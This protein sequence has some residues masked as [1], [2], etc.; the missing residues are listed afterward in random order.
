MILR[1]ARGAL[2]V[3]AGVLVALAISAGPLHADLG[4]PG[5]NSWARMLQYAGCA[6][7]IVTASTGFGMAAAVMMCVHVLVTEA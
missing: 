4:G 3:T 7:G 1:I 2:A 6:L 5:L